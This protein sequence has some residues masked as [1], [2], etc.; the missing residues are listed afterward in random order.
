MGIDRLLRNAEELACLDE[1]VAT[2]QQI[3]YCALPHR[4]SRSDVAQECREGG[5]HEIV[6][7]EPAEHA[8]FPFRRRS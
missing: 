4:H 1:V 3:H 5:E 2:A 8:A 7:A 6:F